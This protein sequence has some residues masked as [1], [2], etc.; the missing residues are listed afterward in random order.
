MQTPLRELVME[1]R[2][3]RGG[4]WEPQKERCATCRHWARGRCEVHKAET[5]A[6][7]GCALHLPKTKA[8]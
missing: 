3:K 4:R 8:N 7:G 6:T 5:K 2:R 1:A